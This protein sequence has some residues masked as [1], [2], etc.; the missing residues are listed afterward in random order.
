MKLAS[1]RKLNMLLTLLG[2]AAIYV[3]LGDNIPDNF[4]IPFLIGL[5]I[6]A[7][8]SVIYGFRPI[9]DRDHSE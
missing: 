4:Q 6:V 5:G 3:F 9:P 2:L 7:V 8:V 1:M